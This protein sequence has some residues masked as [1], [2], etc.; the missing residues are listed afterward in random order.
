MLRKLIK[1]DFI[2]FTRRMLPMYAAV[3]VLFIIAAIFMPTNP[4]MMEKGF[5]GIAG[6]IFIMLIIMSIIAM[7]VITLINI[8]LRFHHNLLGNEGYL[9]HVLPVKPIDH[10]SS[11]LVVSVLFSIFTILV[12]II[13][14]IVMGIILLVKTGNA[15]SLDS[16][17]TLCKDIFKVTLVNHTVLTVLYFIRLFIS[18]INS[19]EMVFLSML[20]GYQHRNKK[21]IMSFVYYVLLYFASN[22]FELL[23]GVALGF[24]I[25]AIKNGGFFYKNTLIN[26]IISNII[27]AVGFFIWSNYLLDKKLNLE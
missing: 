26:S 18:T 8:I 13:S 1:Y 15:N 4:K 17:I 21:V 7:S 10:Y 11:K 5:V 24:N 9:S 12:A 20:L 2:D 19:V 6:F 14:A 3:F 23:V 16:I 22:I 27:I 25:F